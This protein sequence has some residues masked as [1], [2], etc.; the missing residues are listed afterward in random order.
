VYCT[1]YSVLPAKGIPSIQFYLHFSK[2]REEKIRLERGK[3]IEYREGFYKSYEVE[4]AA[5]GVME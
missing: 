3:L 5:S 2:Q 4:E 1:A